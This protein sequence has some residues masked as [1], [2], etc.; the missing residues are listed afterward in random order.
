MVMS[1]QAEHAPPPLVPTAVTQRDADLVARLRLG[2]ERALEELARAYGPKLAT[3][4]L[5]LL[6]DKTFVQDVVQ[7]V[8]FWVWER[9]TT[10]DVRDNLAG[11]LY[12]AIRNRSL[13][14]LR[15]E[16]AQERLAI[17]VVS[18]FLDGSPAVVNTAERALDE[19]DVHSELTRALEHVAARPRRAFLLSYASG[20]TYAEISLVLGVTVESVRKMMYRATRTL[21]EHLAPP[22]SR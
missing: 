21:A 19:T 17:R 12:R 16:R 8:L 22:G 18:G 10:L 7:D 1:E 4:A 9:R 13:D 11:Y 20:L 6:G 2:D 15:H 14:V 5:T 3:V